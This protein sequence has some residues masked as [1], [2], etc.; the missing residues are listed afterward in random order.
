[1]QHKGLK[2][3]FDNATGQKKQATG[4]KFSLLGLR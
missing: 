4:R 1:L 2:F 3:A